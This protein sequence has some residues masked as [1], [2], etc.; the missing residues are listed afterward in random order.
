MPPV[1]SFRSMLQ[2]IPQRLHKLTDSDASR[3]PSGDAWSP[4][5]E[6]GHLLDSAIVNHNRFL[7]MLTEGNPTLPGYDGPQFVEMHKYDE[8]NWQQLISTWETLNTHFLM[9]L[10]TAP[11]ESWQRQGIVDGNQVT[12][13][14]LVTDYIGHA[15]HH[16]QHIGVDVKDLQVS[17][18]A[19]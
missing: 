4:K 3:R 17:G 12:L 14:F 6:L 9:A 2:H 19:A 5:Q 13:D 7:R 16:L 15:L 11:S 1:A 8:R 18:A 10:E